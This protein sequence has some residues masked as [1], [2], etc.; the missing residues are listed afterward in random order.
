MKGRWRAAGFLAGGLALSLLWAANRIEPSIPFP[1][2]S[3]AERVV[4]LTPGDVATFFIDALG[5]NALRLLTAGT[6]LLFLTLGAVLP[7]ISA[8]ARRAR[9]YL[10]GLTLAIA[11]AAA[12]FAAPVAPRPVIAILASLGA[13][14]LYAFS[15][16]WVVE[17]SPVA[18]DTDA[19]RRR[20]LG[21]IGAAALGLAVGGTLLGR[22]SRRLMGP[23][24][25]V[26]IRAPDEPARLPVRPPFPNVPGLS[27]EITSASDHYVVDIDLLDP[28]VE[29]DGWAI[30]VHGLVDRPLRLSFLE[31]QRRFW[32]VEEYSVLTCISNP[33]GG[34]LIGSS[35]WTGVRLG[36]VLSAA[37][38]RGGAVDVVFRCADGYAASIPVA[39]AMHPAVILAIAQNGRPLTWEHGFPCRVRAPAFYGVKNA[40]WVEEIEVV[41]FE[42][43]DYWTT[44]GWTEAATVRTGS[45]IDTV[46]TGLRAGQPTW[47]AGVAWAGARGVSRVEVSVEGGRTW[48]EAMLNPPVSPL[49]WTQWAYRWT[50]PRPGRYRVLCRATDREG[51]SQ[52]PLRRPPHPSGASGYHTVEVEVA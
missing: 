50:P 12:A 33:V 40:K 46:G 10:A 2:L 20:A 9:P 31:L 8:A 18:R 32:L 27:P 42:F 39:G 5:H 17:L 23:N 48:H 14:A 43:D 44:R 35:K 4:R 15:L 41:D 29:A 24:T 3:L 47:V 45:R 37:G 21:L 28:V 13:G 6:I 16:A 38:V 30:T 26:A 25:D 11:A 36:D 49:A 51:R 1:P 19:S 52:G 22:I 34:D 7:A